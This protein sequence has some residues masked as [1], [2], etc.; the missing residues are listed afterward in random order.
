[1]K[2]LKVTDLATLREETRIA[3]KEAKRQELLQK[4]LNG[5][6]VEKELRKQLKTGEELYQFYAELA[7]IPARQAAIL[8]A[9][10]T[11]L[12]LVTELTLILAEH[13]KPQLTEAQLVAV[14]AMKEQL[15]PLRVISL[16]DAGTAKRFHNLVLRKRET[17]QMQAEYEQI[18]AEQKETK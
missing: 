13:V 1:M 17:R 10:E 12:D 15:I 7:T 8:D 3:E 16:D 11:Q 2:S 6:A 18:K 9:I 4:R 5:A 14:Q